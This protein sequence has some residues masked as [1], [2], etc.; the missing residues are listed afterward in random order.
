MC[1]R[2]D[3]QIMNDKPNVNVTFRA[4]TLNQKFE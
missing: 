1:R 3:R 4:I 2:Q